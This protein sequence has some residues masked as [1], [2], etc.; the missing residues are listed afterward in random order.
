MDNSILGNAQTYMGV[1]ATFIVLCLFISKSENESN[2]I[3][4]TL[5]KVREEYIKHLSAVVEE[6]K[7]E[8]KANSEK[9]MS[10]GII[11]VNKLNPV[12][13]AKLLRNRRNTMMIT[14]Q[15]FHNVS[16][17]TKE[18]AP[19]IKN[20]E[21]LPY[22]ALLSLCLII[23]VMLVDC[24]NFLSIGSRCLF[25]NML[26][27]VSFVFTVV[28]Y[29]KFFY[30]NHVNRQVA[31]SETYT[32]KHSKRILF[33]FL[34]LLF[35]GWL[36]CAPYINA[37]WV[38]IVVV[39]ILQILIGYVVKNK[40]ISQC[41]KYKGYSRSI[42]LQHFVVFIVYIGVMTT[43]MWYWGWILPHIGYNHQDIENWNRILILMS[44]KVFCY[45]LCLCFFTINSVVGP[46]VAGYFYLQN[47]ENMIIKNIRE[48]QKDIQPLISELA[49]EYQ[50]ILIQ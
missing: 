22:I 11:P 34:I 31:D 36:V 39:V 8:I 50:K 48:Q 49:K 40:W 13:Q 21:E 4:Y 46:I 24:L 10:G 38:G 17:T 43:G 20:K 12:S 2:F 26:L 18:F 19:E 29:H 14:H 15:F 5:L 27:G 44:S 47:K 9:V 6:I 1:L 28:L 33:V 42:V 7:V 23:T 25:V 41:H 3:I 32:R 37:P 45:Y 30:D 16:D 35:A